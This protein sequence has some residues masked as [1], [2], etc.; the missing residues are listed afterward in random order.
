MQFDHLKRREFIALLG[1]AA[2]WPMAARA[3]QAMPVIGF[4]NSQ[5]PGAFSH[6]VAG[7]L[8]GLNEAGFVEGRNVA[9]EYRWA[10]GQSDRLPTLA[11][12]LVHRGVTVL[13]ATGGE[14]VALAAKAATTAIPIVF[15]IGGDPVTIG[16]VK[17]FNRPGGNVTGLSLLT[18]QI[19]EK[20]VELLAELVPKLNSLGVLINP[21]FPIA[22][23]QRSDILAAAARAG[24][25]VNIAFAQSATEFPRAFA[26][27]TDRRV[28]A[29]LVA[30]SPFFNSRRSEL[31]Q[32]AAQH[33]LPTIYEFREFPM[34]GGL[35]SYGI[36]VVEVYR[37]AAQYTARILK[38]ARPAELPVLQ[39]TKF[40]LVINLNTAKVLGLT[41]PLT[42][43]ASADEVIE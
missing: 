2:A 1:V 43:Q 40:Q 7:F 19:D 13:V 35:I 17:S 11:N 25:Q 9:I 20:R 26:A 6:M 8:R 4:L 24:I 16:L 33:K 22:E 12:D 36:D 28:D 23:K 34:A 39:P 18:F 21:N 31:V 32:L 10:E 5:S 14:P 3:Q 42:L 15:T 37:Q 41:V 27:L 38:G 29:L 30:A